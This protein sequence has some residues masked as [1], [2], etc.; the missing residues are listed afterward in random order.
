MESEFYGTQRPNDISAWEHKFKHCFLFKYHSNGNEA[1]ANE[2]RGLKLQPVAE[3]GDGWGKQSYGARLVVDTGSLRPPFETVSGGSFRGAH[4]MSCACNGTDAFRGQAVVQF[5]TVELELKS[6]LGLSLL[7]SPLRQQ[8]CH[9]KDDN[10]ILFSVV[11]GLGCT[12]D[13]MWNLILNLGLLDNP[14]GQQEYHVKDVNLILF[15]GT[16]LYSH[17]T[18]KIIDDAVRDAAIYRDYNVDGILVENMHDIPYVKA[19]NLSPEITAMMTRVCTEI[20]RILPENIPCGIQI[21]AGC[22]KEAI[23]VAKAADLQF[24]RAEGFVFS[25]IA[26]EGF[27]DACAGSLLRYRKQVDAN[28]ILVF[29]DIKKK[30]SSHAVT[31]DVSLS[32]TVKAAEFFLADGI[33]LTGTATGNPAS[34]TELKDIM[35]PQ[36]IAAGGGEVRSMTGKGRPEPPRLHVPDIA[37]KALSPLLAFPPPALSSVPLLSPLGN[38]LTAQPASRNQLTTITAGSCYHGS[39]NATLMCAETKNK[40]THTFDSFV[41]MENHLLFAGSKALKSK[42]KVRMLSSL[43]N[44][45]LGSNI[46]STQDSRDGS[47]NET[48]ES[49]PVMARLNQ[50][51]VEGDD[52]IL[53]DREVEG[54]TALEESWYV[55]PPAC[56]TRASPVN[57]ETSPLEDLLIEH[58]SMS[59]Y[60]ATAS[61]VAPDTPPPTPDAPEE[62]DVEDDVL[63]PPVS[64]V[65]VVVSLERRA[66]RRTEDDQAVRRPA[67]HDGRPAVGRV[68]AEKRI[69]Q[70]RSAQKV[71]HSSRYNVS[72]R[73]EVY[74]VAEARSPGEEQQAPGGVQ[75]ERQAAPPSG[76]SACP[77]QWREQQPEMLVIR[78][79]AKVYSSTFFLK[80]RKKSKLKSNK[81]R[82]IR[83]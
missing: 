26:D 18:K 58:P 76:P 16:P 52:W 48:P 63:H 7:E 62:R 43:A 55:T 51:E 72:S 57:V 28:D 3:K 39:S 24:I 36:D 80:Q 44:Y 1:F 53:I 54:A 82:N 75:C 27:I 37:L 17:N 19:K 45:L 11:I 81:K 59:V 65:P 29:A 15:R 5:T 4:I 56:F 64:T 42:K 79:Q 60:R 32:E 38:G 47:N 74:P 69:T 35:G 13:Y 66:P 83:R 34:T 46:T 10:L 23:A 33:I 40:P 30:H 71:T 67:I 70:L 50:V 78:S 2:K 49:L 68:T 8:E 9:V 6:R 61:P 21:L 25:H 12:V 14:S 77:E 41:Y 31:S 73:E 22:N 20:K